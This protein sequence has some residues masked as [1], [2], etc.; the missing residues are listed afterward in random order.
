[1]LL[2][3]VKIFLFKKNRTVVK[4]YISVNCDY[5]LVVD[6]KRVKDVGLQR[7]LYMDL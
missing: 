7:V 6:I 3:P 5:S 2:C 4:I 1:M